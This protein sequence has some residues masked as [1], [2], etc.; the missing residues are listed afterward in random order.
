MRRGLIKAGLEVLYWSGI[1]R[2]LAPRTGGRGAILMFHRVR[3]DPSN[4][5]APNAYLE[6]TPA[7]LSAA[8]ALVR[9]SG[10]D[11]VDL[12]EA[13]RRLSDPS[14]GRFCVLTFDDGYRDIFRHAYPVLKE[15]DCPF[16]VYIATGF[17]DR[18]SEAWWLTLEEVVA[19]QGSI[20][21]G[22][23]GPTE[24]F[25]CRTPAQK[26]AAFRALHDWLMRIDEERRQAA[27]RELAW[28]YGVDGAAIVDAE[29]MDWG[30][31]RRL[32]ADPLVTIGAH[33]VGHVSLARLA[34]GKARA[35]MRDGAKVLEAAIG[36]PPRHFAYP[37]GSPSDAGEREFR[38]AAEMGFATAVTSRRGV[39]TASAAARPTAWP[40]VPVSGHYQSV[41]YLDVLLSGVPFAFMPGRPSRAAASRR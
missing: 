12:D 35:E 14:A 33:T 40:R 37:Y 10:M 15:L 17:I 34:A 11:I 2:L 21:A 19:R 32:A 1:H 24:Y 31:V 8:V 28:R 27:I 13:Q 26:S 18:T 29:M 6:V 3:P 36:I 20:A 7:F 4:E 30:E 25:R 16:T 23:D 22:R 38:M 9:Q 39:L 41:R 5:F